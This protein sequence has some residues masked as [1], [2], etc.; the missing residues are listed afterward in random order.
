MTAQKFVK[1]SARHIDIRCRC[2][3]CSKSEC[4]NAHVFLH[5]A[6]RYGYV[7]HKFCA[8]VRG[9]FGT[10]HRN[11]AFDRSER[12]QQTE[13]SR[14]SQPFV[15]V[16]AIGSYMTCMLSHYARCFCIRVPVDFVPLGV[17]FVVLGC[18]VTHTIL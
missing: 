16:R 5:G 6:S 8:T 4:S 18:L 10:R 14:E 9:R 13:Q 12:A 3:R 17:V 1:K 2:C 11:I 7:A 15:C